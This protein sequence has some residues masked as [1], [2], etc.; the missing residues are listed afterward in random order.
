M[1]KKIALLGMILTSLTLWSQSRMIP[2]NTS[3]SN[4]QWV[5]KKVTGQHNGTINLQSGV[6]E[7]TAGVLS[8]GQFEVNM[9]TIS[10]QDLS[11][12]Y[13]NKLDGHLKS[14]D[15]FGV[16]QYPTA[17]MVITN[18][19]QKMPNHYAINGDLTIKGITHP[20]FF[21]MHFEDQS[22]QAKVVIDRAKYDVKFRS[23]SFFENL[24]D[25]LIYDDFELEVAL[26]F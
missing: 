23:G 4:I 11:G 9:T 20:V 10:C 2:I 18:A 16:E 15:F 13:K 17:T 24:G 3:E 25:N 21:E 26:K 14:D 22:A 19:E 8:G 1:K 12:E 7:M 5:G 6:L